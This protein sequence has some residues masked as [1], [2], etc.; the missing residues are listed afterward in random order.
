[1]LDAVKPAMKDATDTTPAVDADDENNDNHDD[2]H[3]HDNDENDNDDDEIQVL[4]TI[5]PPSPA[6]KDASN[7]VTPPSSSTWPVSTHK[8]RVGE[9]TTNHTAYACLDHSPKPVNE[10]DRDDGNAALNRTLWSD[11]P[12]MDLSL[13]SSSILNSSNDNNQFY[14]PLDPTS[15]GGETTYRT[16]EPTV[17]SEPSTTTMQSPLF[18]S[19][20]SAYLQSLAEICHAILWDVRWRVDGSRQERLLAWERGDDLSAV[21]ALARR[22]LPLSP[23]PPVL[24]CQCLLCYQDNPDHEKSD[25]VDHGD[26][27]IYVQQMHQSRLAAT[28]SNTENVIPATE[29]CEKDE[30]HDR[31]LNLYARLYS[32]KG[33]WFRVDDIFKYYIP[34]RSQNLS[35]AVN[36]SFHT[37]CAAKPSSPSKFFL[38]KSA[39]K[40]IAT[41]SID[42]YIDQDYV[43]LQLEAVTTMLQDV[44]QLV[45]MGLLRSFQSEQECGQT[46]GRMGK[47]EILRQEEQRSILARLGGAGKHS[48]RASNNQKPTNGGNL[49]WKQMCQ[50]QSILAQASASATKSVLLPVAKHVDE[51]LIASWATSLVL[52]ASHGNYI[53]QGILRS[54][55]VPV[56]QALQQQLSDSCNFRI[57]WTCLRLREAPLK[58]LRRCCRLYLCATS[59]PGEMRGDTGI[60]AWKSLPHEVVRTGDEIIPFSTNTVAPPNAPDW[61]HTSIPGREFRFKLISCTFQRAHQPLSLNKPSSTVQSMT[62]KEILQ[63]QVFST[64]NAF[65]LWELSVVFRSNVDY[66]LEA[67]EL[68]LYNERKRA[69]E[70]GDKKQGANE[71]CRQDD[72]PLTHDM[73]D[74]RPKDKDWD[75]PV[76]FLN[77]LKQS[78]RQKILKRFA[79]AMTMG[80]NSESELEQQVESDVQTLLAIDGT[81]HLRRDRLKNDCERVLAVIA[82][83]AANVLSHRNDSASSEDV[84]QVVS[85]PWLRHLWW[86]GCM[87]YLLWDIIPILERR[88]YYDVATNALEILLFGRYQPRNPACTT[89]PETLATN[90]ASSLAQV[91]LSRRARGKAFERLV[92]DYTHILRMQQ[93]DVEKTGNKKRKRY[94]S[95]L[96]ILSLDVHGVTTRLCEELILSK[97]PTGQITFSAARTLA[98]RL[99][100]PLSETLSKLAV[101]EIK[102]L[103]HRLSSPDQAMTSHKS[104]LT[105]G[106]KV[107]KR[108]CDWTPTT[109]QAVANAMTI[110]GKIAVGSRCR[111]VGFEEREDAPENYGSLNV[112]ELAMEF[113]NTGRLPVQQS[114]ST[115]LGGWVGWH[116]EGG[117]VRALFRILSSTTV[118]GT[119]W[120]CPQN[121]CDAIQNATIHLTPYQGAPFDLHVGAE[122]SGCN[123]ARARLGFYKRR[124][125]MIDNFLT[126]LEGLQPTQIANLVHRSIFARWQCALKTQQNDPTLARDIQQARTLSALA[127]GFGGK[128]LAVMCRCLFFDYRHYSGGLPDLTLF[129]AVY[130]PDEIHEEES[131]VDLGCWIGEAFCPEQHAASV[132]SKIANMFQDQDDEFLGC[133]RA[134]DSGRRTNR[135]GR[136]NQS[137]RGEDKV[138]LKEPKRLTLHHLGRNVRVECMLVEVKSQNDRL[139]ARQE[140]WLNVLDQYGNV[141]VCKFCAQTKGE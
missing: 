69:R 9:T 49:I 23:P 25:T 60:N 117:R 18:S 91:Y 22:Y 45:S 100:Q 104:I 89:I 112:E 67:N 47:Y 105:K 14:P 39:Q 135:Q 128:M 95:R 40:P 75:S 48:K 27:N 70:E 118:L 57:S 81:H 17:I 122:Q 103:G 134:G 72:L 111:F 33:P 85:R 99:K 56:Q 58:S 12:T 4:L 113:Y 26:N 3:D 90:M 16:A 46:I 1:M 36:E 126:C 59:G 42:S 10:Y 96:S 139:D 93:K 125:T 41:K 138:A 129:R 136:P 140:D 15:N 130:E 53:P 115:L 137:S 66:L 28:Y 98:R 35:D 24:D 86:E 121:T 29:T 52:R 71:P 109:D 50:Q 43:T 78:G 55:T 32:R 13:S 107:S 76:D 80:S 8:L 37:T 114:A 34:K 6:K 83:L 7:A 110:G 119:D 19:R 97:I 20:T 77:V 64:V 61:N 124:R 84:N 101:Y 73:V 30:P 31:A 87:A 131:L 79:P 51:I 11:S 141:R 127:A 88:G 132:G 74:K 65:E 116:D 133:S 54:V 94:D 102:E 62:E 106:S 92:I 108:Y 2:D 123:S 21:H 68:S 82:I 63:V 5:F 44:Q 38:P 120:S